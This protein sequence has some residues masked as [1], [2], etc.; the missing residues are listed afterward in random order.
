MSIRLENDWE[1]LS[2]DLWRWGAYLSSTNKTEIDNVSSVEY[3]LHPT[4]KNPIRTIKERNNNFRLTTQGW[5][6]FILR[7][8]VRYGDGRVTHLQ[9]QVVLKREP[10]QGKTDK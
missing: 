10:P 1:Y 9:H 3:L 2:E 7:A 5:G 4:F 8:N 6:T